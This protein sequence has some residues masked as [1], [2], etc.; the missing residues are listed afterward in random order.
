[1]QNSKTLMQ[2]PTNWIALFILI[3][4]L[5]SL[6]GYAAG[7]AQGAAWAAPLAPAAA[8]SDPVSMAQPESS[9]AGWSLRYDPLEHKWYAQHLMTTPQGLVVDEAYAL[10]H[11]PVVPG[12]GCGLYGNEPDC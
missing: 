2:I 4:A 6:G 10:E 5:A 8:V 3:A 1:M 12:T 9:P 7:R 11:G